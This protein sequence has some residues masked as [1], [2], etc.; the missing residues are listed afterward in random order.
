MA[1]ETVLT[2]LMNSIA[3]TDQD[4]VLIDSDARMALDAFP[5]DGFV[6]EK[7]SVETALMRC[8]ALRRVS[9]SLLLYKMA[10]W[11][12]DTFI[13][14]C[15]SCCWIT[16]SFFMAILSFQF[17]FSL[18]FSLRHLLFLFHA[19]LNVIYAI[20][21]LLDSPS[22]LMLPSHSKSSVFSCPDNFVS[23]S[24]SNFLL[25]DAFLLDFLH[26]LHH[27]LLHLILD[28]PEV[29]LTSFSDFFLCYSISHSLLPQVLQVFISV[30]V[31]SF[32]CTHF[33]RKHVI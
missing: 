23:R 17:D 9:I 27:S 19:R 11:L 12:P 5:R 28:L 21:S 14:L 33:H 4:V 29:S 10:S 18:L 25:F 15:T 6:T 1:I 24:S 2:E 8:P 31:H 7:P 32:S 30:P 22:S 13:L 20:D 3:H 26:L 16:A